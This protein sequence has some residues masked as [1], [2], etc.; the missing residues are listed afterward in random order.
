MKI[1]HLSKEY[2]K[3]HCADLL[4]NLDGA[5]VGNKTGHVGTINYLALLFTYLER[6]FRILAFNWSPE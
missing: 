1:R 3:K 2:G 6:L 4:F 5:G